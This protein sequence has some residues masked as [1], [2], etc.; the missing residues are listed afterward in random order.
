MKKKIEK[1]RGV[2]LVELMIVLAI[3]S[4]VM[5]SI[6]S[7]YRTHQRTAFTQDEVVEVQ[8]NLRIGMENITRDIRMAGFLIPY[9]TAPVSVVNDNTGV[10]QPLPA[11]DN[12]SS[13]AITIS[14]ASASATIGRIVQPP[15]GAVLTME[16]S[17]AVDPFDNGNAVTIIRPGNRTLP[18]GD[19]AGAGCFTI[20]G[21]NSAAHS[22]TLASPPGGV[23]IEGDLL[24]EIGACGSYPNTITYCLGPSTLPAPGGCGNS[25]ATCPAGQLCLMRIV[26]GTAQLI[27]QNM[28]G[29]QISYLMDDG[30]ETAAPATLNTIRSVRVTLIGQTVTTKAFSD[31]AS[32]VRRLES[33]IM[34]RNR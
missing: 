25:V 19:P 30:T 18:A 31:N 20:N 3:L 21:K 10:A 6:Y 33:V 23:I 9:N 28:A 34:M 12:V 14:T 26:N 1:T 7:L 11:P 27:A 5:M 29:L 16:S 8:Q 24:V 32:K 22:I 13:D 4:L 2:T 15:A 17:Q